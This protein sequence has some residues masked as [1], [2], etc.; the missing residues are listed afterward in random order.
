MHTQALICRLNSEKL[1][2]A[3]DSAPAAEG[4]AIASYE[5]SVVQQAR[6]HAMGEMLGITPSELL[7]QLL[8]AC[9]ADAHDGFLAAYS[10]EQQKQ[11]DNKTLKEKSLYW[12]NL[13]AAVGN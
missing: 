6:I 11:Q 4:T 3:G 8:D 12:Q 5:F 1:K 7:S 13:F 9:L 10:C 2:A